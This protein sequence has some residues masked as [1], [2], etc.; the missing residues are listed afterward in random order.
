MEGVTPLTAAASE[1]QP[2]RGP[3]ADPTSVA[4][5][6]SNAFYGHVSCCSS[7]VQLPA[8]VRR[9]GVFPTKMMLVSVAIEKKQPV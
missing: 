5:N 3:A 6:G 7:C 4:F 9:G 8:E 2:W 1:K